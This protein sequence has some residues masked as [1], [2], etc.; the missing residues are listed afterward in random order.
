MLQPVE[1]PTEKVTDPVPEPP[2]LDK[3]AVLPKATVLGVE[4]AVKAA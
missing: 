2:E 3:V 4:M 1:A